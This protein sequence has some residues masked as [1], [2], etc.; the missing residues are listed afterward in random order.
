M[1]FSWLPLLFDTMQAQAVKLSHYVAAGSWC[2]IVYQ[3][4]MDD[5]EEE[6][7]M[8]Q[9]AHAVLV[10]LNGARYESAVFILPSSLPEERLGAYRVVFDSTE[11]IY[12]V[13]KAPRINRAK[14][15]A[16]I[17]LSYDNPISR[18]LPNTIHIVKASAS[19]LAGSA[20]TLPITSKPRQ[21]EEPLAD[22][23]PLTAITS[24][25]HSIP[26][27][28]DTAV[29]TD[30][31][32]AYFHSP[33][34]EDWALMDEEEK[35]KENS[36]K[37]EQGLELV[38][39]F[40]QVVGQ[41][42]QESSSQERNCSDTP[43]SATSL[44]DI[45]HGEPSGIGRLEP[46]TAITGPPNSDNTF[47][48]PCLRRY[49]L[50]QAETEILVELE[51][52]VPDLELIYRD[53]KQYIRGIVEWRYISEASK[54]LLACGYSRRRPQLEKADRS[55]A[56]FWNL[57]SNANTMGVA[58]PP[59]AHVVGLQLTNS[60]RRSAA[61]PQERP[62][63]RLVHHI[64]Y[65]GRPVACRSATPPAVSLWAAF[66]L[67]A[68]DRCV[69]KK[70]SLRTHVL[71]SQAGLYLDPFIIN[72]LE[73]VPGLSGT[74]LQE[75]VTGYVEK[76]Y[77][78]E[79]TWQFEE[80]EPDEDR[81][82]SLFEVGYI[83]DGRREDCNFPV[84]P[85]L[86][87][88]GDDVAV[89]DDGRVHLVVPTLGRPSRL[90]HMESY[91]H[92][93]DEP[94]DQLPSKDTEVQQDANFPVEDH[95]SK[96]LPQEQGDTSPLGG[97]VLSDGV[98]AVEDWVEDGPSAEDISI[99]LEEINK[100]LAL[101]PLSVTSTP[102]TESPLSHRSTS[103]DDEDEP[104]EYTD[105]SSP[106]SPGVVDPSC[107]PS[108]A[109]DVV[110]YTDF[111]TIINDVG[112]MIEDVES[113]LDELASDCGSR[114]YEG[115]N[116]ESQTYAEGPLANVHD[117]T[118]TI[119]LSIEKDA[120][121]QLVEELAKGDLA[122]ATEDKAAEEKG[123][124]KDVQRDLYELSSCSSR[125]HGNDVGE[126]DAGEGSLAGQD[127]FHVA[128]FLAVEE[129]PAPERAKALVE[130]DIADAPIDEIGQEKDSGLV[131]EVIQGG[132]PSET[133]MPDVVEETSAT[134]SS[135]HQYKKE[136]EPELVEAS[137]EGHVAE[138]VADEVV[139]E[140]DSGVVE[141]FKE[142]T[143]EDTLEEEDDLHT[144]TMF[145]PVEEEAAP[146]FVEESAEGHTA[147]APGEK[148]VEEETKVTSASEEPPQDDGLKETSTAPELIE[149]SVEDE[150][151]DSVDEEVV[152]EQAFGEVE[153]SEDAT[154]EVAQ[155]E[156][157]TVEH[158]V[159]EA[160]V[161]D[162]AQGKEDNKG[163]AEAEVSASDAGGISG[164]FFG[165][166]SFPRLSD[167]LLYG[168]IA[169]YAGFRVSRALRR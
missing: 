15:M 85:Y 129:E 54:Q 38:R 146:K 88:G 140:K 107:S 28:G 31:G 50:E 72:D 130:V 136:A 65:A 115:S 151:D 12:Q 161:G 81:P 132:V 37:R 86:T 22:P 14:P 157:A 80:L 66:S 62:S 75:F 152:E 147:D 9:V 112:K 52:F 71:A 122:D 141:E 6:Q 113:D 169:A 49:I 101:K 58:A 70:Y 41:G 95:S 57:D 168:S 158:V 69:E 8:A 126:L 163:Q 99:S 128:I 124:T 148:V 19:A 76:V 125:D 114:D 105:Q 155:E 20:N 1:A 55:V 90:S 94:V 7:S 116:E 154:Q 97:L 133:G 110:Q 79:G 48:S 74:E 164:Q 5:S 131:E 109:E 108:S 10:N 29:N 2:E 120:T 40:N 102:T 134:D 59:Q 21:I 34:G 32:H 11:N 47:P 143:P 25:A 137:A 27:K 167:C 16:P 159:E 121:P 26:K 44:P 35:E 139:A 150:V 106:R 104:T 135:Q 123:L 118:T 17:V 63:K 36:K 127:D 160:P 18:A 83:W 46:T 61:A 30:A 165:T 13:S 92:F 156:T 153:A 33:T 87:R 51:K 142:I 84:A 119:S 68:A 3:Q 67:G 39:A 53:V 100:H 64:N 149:E 138:A 77:D 145:P 103:S 93:P 4:E 23:S 60:P 111:C 91:E 45:E 56:W 78:Q 117:I 89:N 73:K 98:A 166:F 162:C 82:R 43:P 24:S 96:S 144:K 42:Y